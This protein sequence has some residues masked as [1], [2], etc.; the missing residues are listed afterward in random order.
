MLII[1][2]GKLM[3]MQARTISHNVADCVIL[4]YLDSIFS[5]DSSFIHLF[6]G[7]SG[8]PHDFGNPNNT[9]L[10]INDLSVSLYF[11][12]LFLPSVNVVSIK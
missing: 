6:D 3:L 7:L 11:S 1:F 9:Q 5:Q 10:S 4:K 12:F 8:S 2:V